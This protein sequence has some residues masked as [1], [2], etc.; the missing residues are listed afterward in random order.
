MQRTKPNFEAVPE[1]PDK[2]EMA[3]NSLNDS[4]EVIIE[5][6]EL[7]KSITFFGV[8]AILIANIGGSGIFITPTTILR[9][10]G[11]PGMSVI[12]W[13]LGGVVQ[14]S[15]AFCAIEIVLMFNK[16]GGP[17]YLIYHTFGDLAGFVFM[18]G[19]VI[20]IAGPSW[21]LGSYTA[22]LYT[23]SVVYTNCP[24]PDFLV[25]LVALWLMVSLMALNCTYMKVVTHIQKVLTLC[26]IL[27][28]VIIIIVG[29]ALVP[30]GQF[31]M[32][33]GFFRSCN[34]YKRAKSLKFM[35]LV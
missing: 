3:A 22:S 9:F 2:E 5:K 26:K 21:A 12:L 14:A 13:M 19:F 20:F 23:L 30:S 4:P 15:L 6:V 8:I 27:A 1:E 24:P 34:K 25:K 35:V 28:L 29:L 32:Y 31:K 11:S 17:Y 7:K 16:A 33:C 10:S 18:W